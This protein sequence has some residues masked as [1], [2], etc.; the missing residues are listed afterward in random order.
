MAQNRSLQPQWTGNQ[1]QDDTG[2]GRNQQRYGITRTIAHPVLQR[3]IRQAASADSHDPEQE[4]EKQAAIHPPSVSATLAACLRLL[5]LR[6][7]LCGARRTPHQL[8]EEIAH[9]DRRR[10]DEGQRAGHLDGRRADARCEG[11][12]ENAFAEPAG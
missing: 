3:A 8:A 11:G 4:I 2:E 1:H 12:V 9:P 5:G 6:V 10:L 7:L